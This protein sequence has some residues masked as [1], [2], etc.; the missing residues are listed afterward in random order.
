MEIVEDGLSCV[1][2]LAGWDEDVTVKVG[3]TLRVGVSG[4]MDVPA[5]AGFAPPPRTAVWV[6]VCAYSYQLIAPRPRVSCSCASS[7]R[8]L[9]C[10]TFLCLFCLSSQYT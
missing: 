2:D 6:C 7:A 8:P 5:V 4:A 9:P 3:A 10:T 1:L